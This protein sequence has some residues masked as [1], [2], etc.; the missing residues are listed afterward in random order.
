LN[1]GHWNLTVYGTRFI[2]FAKMFGAGPIQIGIGYNPSPFGGPAW[3]GPDCNP[4][5]TNFGS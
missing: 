4:G 5:F 1:A 3:P 2:R